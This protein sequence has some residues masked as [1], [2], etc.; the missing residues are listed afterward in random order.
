MLTPD[1]SSMASGSLPGA[2]PATSPGSQ[3]DNTRLNIPEQL[4]QLD[5]SG[6]K[7]KANMK[8]MGGSKYDGN[9][10]P[11]AGT[12]GRDPTTPE[13]K[14]QQKECTNNLKI[15]ANGHS[16][17]VSSLSPAPIASAPSLGKNSSVINM[18][19][20]AQYLVMCEQACY[21]GA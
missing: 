3:G 2:F 18:C 5:L 8:T 9:A 1:Y 15:G 6:I 14:M 4:A 12:C 16:S 10:S 20:G 19:Y 7:Q 11:E 21:T 17:P 13:E